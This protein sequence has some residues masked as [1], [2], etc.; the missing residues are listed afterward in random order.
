MRACGKAQAEPVAVV[1][2]AGPAGIAAALW[3]R[4]LELPFRWLE[5]EP[6]VGGTLRRVGNPVRNYPGLDAASGPCLVAR[7]VQHLERLDLAPERATVTGI[8]GAGTAPPRLGLATGEV[9]T[10]AFT[11]LCTGTRPRLLGLPGESE[12]LGAGVEISV[13]RTRDRYAGRTVAIVGGGDAAL[14][15]ALLLAECCPVVHLIHRR[16]VFRGQARFI[17]AVRSHPTIHLHLQDHVAR[18]QPQPDALV[19]ELASGASLPVGGLFVRIGVA[20]NLPPGLPPTLLDEAGY[21]RTNACGETSWPGLLAAGDVTG[22][23][24]QSVS[25]AVG[26]AARAVAAIQRAGGPGV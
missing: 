25:A 1:V 16:E 13:T 9:L 10:P 22:P 4:D 6:E 23:R 15:G 12:L 11:L 2:G 17:D 21:L 14:E 24:H 26:S 7:F 19:V 8:D 20:P 5:Q 3:L 18:L